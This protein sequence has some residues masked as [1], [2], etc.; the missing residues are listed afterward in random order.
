MAKSDRP[1]GRE[2]D[3]APIVGRLETMWQATRDTMP[4]FFDLLTKVSLGSD[5]WHNPRTGKLA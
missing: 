5:P 2:R 4:A 3:T 1:N